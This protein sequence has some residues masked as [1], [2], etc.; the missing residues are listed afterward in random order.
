MFY[1][2]IIQNKEIFKIVYAAIV[3]LICALIVIK[4]DK[5]FKLSFH[6]GI[7]YLRNAFFFYGVAFV[8]RYFIK[9]L[10]EINYLSYYS[11]LVDSLFEFFLV[12]AGFFLLYSLLWKKFENRGPLSFSS[13]LNP[14]VLIFYT[15]AIVIVLLDFLW[16]NYL[17]MFL[18]QVLIFV[19]VSFISYSNYRKDN[20]QH[21]FPKFYF[22]A[23]VIALFAWILNA[24]AQ[25]YFNWDQ[26]IM[27]NVYLLNALFFLLFLY[28]VIK[29]TKN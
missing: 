12:M 17:F 10:F 9:F 7:R 2:S 5:L 22:V 6:D 8:I 29:V 28:G 1:D 19:Y 13:L 23:M 24:L 14:R 26:I 3:V 4:T 25:I 27:I 11:F 15:L 21:R 18:T 16:I 20:Y